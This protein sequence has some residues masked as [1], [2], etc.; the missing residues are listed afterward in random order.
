MEVG[1]IECDRALIL[2]EG[3]ENDGGA[4]LIRGE[5]EAVQTALGLLRRAQ[6][7]GAGAVYRQEITTRK[8]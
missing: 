1:K 7:P 3:N 5:P 4:V 6:F 2:G 8:I